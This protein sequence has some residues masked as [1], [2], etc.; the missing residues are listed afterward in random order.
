MAVSTAVAEEA[1]SNV[2]TVRAFSNEKKVGQHYND[3][4]EEY[5][6]LAKR[7]GISIGIF[8]GMY[9]IWMNGAVVLVMLYG[10]KLVSNG[11]LTS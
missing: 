5:Y 8:Q 2:R 7:L 3:T 1:V 11:E 6:Q 10:G 4:V 9:N